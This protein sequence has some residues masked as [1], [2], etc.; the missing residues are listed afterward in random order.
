MWADVA[1]EVGAT[2]AA[3]SVRNTASKHKHER[4]EESWCEEA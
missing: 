1:Q 2:V 3:A 4:Y